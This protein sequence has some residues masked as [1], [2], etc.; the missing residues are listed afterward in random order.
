MASPMPSRRSQMENQND[1][2][3]DD[4]GVSTSVDEVRDESRDE[5]EY[6]EEPIPQKVELTIKMAEV[7]KI[8][9]QPGDILFF[10]FK[11]D[12]FHSTDVNAIGAELRKLFPAK[13]VVVMALPDN[14]DVELTTIENQ[15]KVMEEAKDCSKPTSYCNDC[16]CGKKERIENGE[17]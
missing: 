3:N 14:H 10:K 15:D 12:E 17:G 13:K 5:V 8:T 6:F 9:P 4:H 7:M 1:E 11:G 16:S 2:P